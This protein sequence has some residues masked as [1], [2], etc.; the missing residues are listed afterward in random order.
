MTVERTKGA[1]LQGKATVGKEEVWDARM[2]GE[3]KGL[4]EDDPIEQLRKGCFRS[5]C[6]T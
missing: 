6:L 1:M 3:D 4:A 5:G 2:V